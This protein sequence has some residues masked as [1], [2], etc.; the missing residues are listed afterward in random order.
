LSAGVELGESRDEKMNFQLQ[1][2]VLEQLS[3]VGILEGVSQRVMMSRKY[4][5][6]I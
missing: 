1:V 4:S 3:Q 5:V 6:D 2:R